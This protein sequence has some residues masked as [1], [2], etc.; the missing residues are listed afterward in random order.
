MT[1][2]I[3]RPHWLVIA[4]SRS[5]VPIS[6]FL[7]PTCEMAV[8]QL[9]VGFD[10]ILRPMDIALQ[11]RV[12]DVVERLDAADQLIEFEDRLSDRIVLRQGTK[13]A[14]KC[15][16]AHL[17]EP[18]DGDDPV[19][20]ILLGGDQAAVDQSGR[21]QEVRLAL[22]DIA[23]AIEVLELRLKAGDAGGKFAPNQCVTAKFALLT[24]CMSPV[25]V[26]GTIAEVL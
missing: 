26:V 25:I 13:L 11:L 21:R 4:T 5:V 23:G 24:V 20:I 1:L 7:P 22:C 18:Q 8:A 9:V 19:D 3:S 17:L 15:A 12:P 14:D 2:A 16:L 6:C 10:T